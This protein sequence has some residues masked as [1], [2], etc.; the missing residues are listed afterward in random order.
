MI[1]HVWLGRTHFDEKATAALT[2]NEKDIR[3][4]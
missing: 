4:K 1:G 3:R 2:T